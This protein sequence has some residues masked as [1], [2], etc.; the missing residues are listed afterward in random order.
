[1]TNKMTPML[2]T[3]IITLKVLDSRAPTNKT[4]AHSK[5]MTAASGENEK[6]DMGYESSKGG[7]FTPKP[8][9]ACTNEPDQL[10]AVAEALIAYSKVKHQPIIQAT[11]S[12][13]AT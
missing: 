2:K 9:S 5:T 3:V 4:S 7:V 13:K 6:T 12:P 11:S 8:C 1:M 10:R